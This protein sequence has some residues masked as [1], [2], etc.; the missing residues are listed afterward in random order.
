[1]HTPAM[2]YEANDLG[3]EYCGKGDT[4]HFP[5]RVVGVKIYHGKFNVLF[6][7]FAFFKNVKT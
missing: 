3:A 1:M 4:E 2:R 7:I 6:F 5:T